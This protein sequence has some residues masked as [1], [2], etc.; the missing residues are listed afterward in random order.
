MVIPGHQWYTTFLFMSPSLMVALYFQYS[1]EASVQADYMSYL[2]EEVQSQ[3][4][5][6]DP[7]KFLFF[8]FPMVIL[9]AALYYNQNY[10]TA[11]LI[12][13]KHIINK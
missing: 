1:Y 13:E 4:E 8:Q 9:F 11:S 6:I 5:P 10:E 12:V 3:I 2:P 7:V